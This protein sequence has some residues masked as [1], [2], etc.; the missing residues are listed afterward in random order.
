MSFYLPSKLPRLMVAPN[1]VRPMKKDHPKVPI[2]IDEI[3]ET[4]KLSYD[5]GAEAIHFHI[6]D[7]NGLHVLDFKKCSEAI[8]KLNLKTTKL[9][10][11]GQIQ[12]K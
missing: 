9:C 8:L 7:E 5:A 4:A 10:I 6:R 12:K 11:H 1:G 2:T 3:V